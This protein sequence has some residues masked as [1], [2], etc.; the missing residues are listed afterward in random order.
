MV[1]LLRICGYILLFVG[2]NFFV[3]PVAAATP[4][5]LP[6]NTD[7]TT[8]IIGDAFTVTASMSGAVSASAYFLKCRIGS[9]GSSLSDGQTY[10]GQTTQWLDDSGSNGAWID[11]PQITTDGDGV[12]QGSVQCRIKNSASDEVKLIFI[13][14]CLNSSNSCG[15]SFQSANSLTVNPIMPTATPTLIP[16]NTPTP[17]PEHTNTPTPT[18]TRTPTPTKTPTPTV[19][20]TAIATP[21]PTHVASVS[22]V[23]GVTDSPATASVLADRETKPSVK[24]LIISLLFVGIGCGILSLVFLWKKRNELKPPKT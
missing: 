5:I 18:P 10:N 15:T 20:P 4:N 3:W 23:L 2:I 14:A 6:L 22:A 9:N 19:K 16:T 11:M 7:T 17:T 24:P 8:P 13:R 1:R 21:T 12:W